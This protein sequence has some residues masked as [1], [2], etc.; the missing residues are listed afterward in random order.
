MQGCRAMIVTAVCIGSSV[1]SASAN[2]D[3]APFPEGDAALGSAM[4][5]VP[6]P[7]LFDLVRP[8]G[9]HVDSSIV[10]WAPEIE[11]AFADGYA[12]ELEFPFVDSDLVE[13][14]AR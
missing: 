4:P 12:V 13:Y 2:V 9:E 10:E 14:K 11:Y 8:L 7:L 6:E 1:T 3:N 5:H